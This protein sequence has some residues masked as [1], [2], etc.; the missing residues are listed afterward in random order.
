MEKLG[1]LE[2][3]E[4]WRKISRHIGLEMTIFLVIWMGI[5]QI[6]S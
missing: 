3:G 4:N 5:V 1:E 6:V 2:R